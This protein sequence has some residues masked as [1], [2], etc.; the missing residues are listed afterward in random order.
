MSRED[1]PR[2]R[3]HL[4]AELDHT[5][6]EHVLLY[7]RLRVSRGYLRLHLLQLEWVK[8]FDGTRTLLDIQMLAMRQ[9]GGQ[10]IPLA[11]I[12]QLAGALEEVLFLDSPRWR[13]AASDPVRPPTCVGVYEG[14]P[15]ALREQLG[16]LF[17]HPRSSGHPATMLDD[18]RVRAV[19]LPHIDFARGGVSYTW[20]LKEL[21]ESTP[22]RL[23]VIVGTAHHSPNRFTLTSKHFRTPLGIVTTDQGYID[24]LVEN[25]GDG[26]FDDELRAHLPEHSIELEVV[27][28]QYLYEGKRDFRIV[29]LV[30]GTFDD[31][32]NSDRTP[33]HAEDIRRMVAALRAAERSAGEPVCYIIS[34]DLAHIGPKFRDPSPVDRRQLEHSRRQDEALIGAAERVDLDGYFQV[35][36]QEGDERRICGLPPTWLTLSAAR[37]SS[38]RLTHYGQYVDPEGDESV[39]FAS[40]VFDA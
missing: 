33:D 32:V 17:D 3:P 10:I 7:D 23:F 11:V 19:L 6:G 14:E 40:M 29:P 30:V 4:A 36:A 24:R 5:T 1:R 26:L 18:G 37:P 21:V 2:L 39:S 28:L 8:L 35:I 9:L 31:C 16:D 13:A 34:G 38:G 27:L 15:E 20:A 25:Y 12:E 22:A